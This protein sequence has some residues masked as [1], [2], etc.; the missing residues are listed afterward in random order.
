MPAK[1]NRNLFI[2]SIIIIII[3]IIIYIIFSLFNIF[4]INYQSETQRVAFQPRGLHNRRDLINHLSKC[5]MKFPTT[6][7]QIYQSGLELKKMTFSVFSLFSLN[8]CEVGM[9]Y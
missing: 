3:I 1:D 2:I 7:S 8:F 5:F 6:S 4:F 9:S